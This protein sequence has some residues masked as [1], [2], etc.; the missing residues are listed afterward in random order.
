MASYSGEQQ[1]KTVINTDDIKEIVGI[2]NNRFNE[3]YSLVSFDEQNQFE[4]LE[5]LNKIFTHLDSRW[6]I[7]V[8][9]DNQDTII[10]KITEY[11][12]ILNYPGQFDDKWSQSVLIADKKVIYPIF[13]YLLTRYPELEKRA[14]LAKYLVP[15]FVPD[16]FQMD[17]DI[18]TCVD[19]IKDLQAQFQVHHQSLEQVQSQ[20]MQ[21]EELKKD[22]TQ[23]EQ[24]REQL[25]NKISNFKSKVLT[26]P[27]FNELLDVTNMLRKEQEEE[28]RLQDKLRQQRMT[29][30]QTDQQ[31]L[32]A[33]QR[34]IDAQK[35]LSPDNSPEQMLMALRNEVKRNRE[36]SKDRL[37]F[38][39][40][41]RRKK[42]EQ[43]ERLLAE[44]PITLNEL[45]NL[46]NT[47]MALRRAV[48]QME[49]KLK[50][51]AKPEDD[52]LTIYKQQ[53]QLVAKKKERAVEDIK[54]VEEEQQLI[55]KEVFKKEDQIAKERG[56]NY[57]TKGEFKE[58]ANQLKDKKFQYQ[59][60]K[61]ELKA[62][63]AERSTLE[64]TEQILRKQKTEL[65]KQQQELE[66]THGIVGYSKKKEGLEKLSEENQQINLQKGQTLEEI[67]KIV[68]EIQAQIQLKR[69]LIQEQLAEIKTVRQ[70]YSDLEQEHKKKKQEFD[71]IMLG[72]ESDQS[73]LVTDVKKLR[74]EV[75]AFD[76]KIKL[77]K[78]NS[79]IL[80][81]K[82]Q[83]LNDEIEYSKGG[84]QL[85]SQ[86]KSNAEMLQQRILKLEEN[87]KNLK[88]QREL[89]KENYEP[90]LRQMNY[91]SDLKK[92]LNVKFQQISNEQGQ[93]QQMKAG[94]NRL[95]IG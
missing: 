60:L 13:H 2:L 56:P 15:V 55:E 53:A 30:D 87:I 66:K 31:L 93:K 54:K 17:N 79:E 78:F 24:E 44:P 47:L 40:K 63:Q 4:F 64:R 48:N 12:R 27:N 42:L 19:Q 20:S 94:A 85:S 72:V 43:I 25:L 95:V 46:E 35:S 89:V 37:G 84:K 90:S 49:D 58:Y 26:K 3:N 67:S 23:F 36:I 86:F 29:L 8:K 14:Y 80:E 52:K 62:L 1:V 74:D 91:F 21:P 32:Q 59:K 65:L 68:N 11:L 34:L 75:Y 51:E 61:D 50:R 6:T 5:L 88:Q 33:Q 22:I 82:I 57:K 69:P 41:E 92:I 7:D 81:I 39:L 10:Y 73:S 28:A 38:D 83:R 9:V 18:K 16:E 71:R 77:N 45:N 70:Q 76:R